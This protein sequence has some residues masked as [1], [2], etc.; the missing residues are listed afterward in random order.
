MF[1]Y[2]G[3]DEQRQVQLEPPRRQ[4]S[5]ATLSEQLNDRRKAIGPF[6]ENP[7]CQTEGNRVRLT[8]WMCLPFAMGGLMV[9]LR[10]LKSRSLASDHRIQWPVLP[11]DPL[12]CRGQKTDKLTTY[13]SPH[14]LFPMPDSQIQQAQSPHESREMK[15]E[16]RAAKMACEPSLTEV[17][18]GV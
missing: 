9:D 13:W 5:S 16:K 8:W 6:E 10:K 17:L 3:R 18:E 1:G 12:V 15:R 2:G 11:R 14:S 4:P 7:L